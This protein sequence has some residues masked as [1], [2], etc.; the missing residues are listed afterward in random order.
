[1][2][3]R[4]RVGIIVLWVVSLAAVGLWG[5]TRVPLSGSR[6]ISGPDLGFRVDRVEGSRVTGTLMIKLDGQWMVVG[7]A[8]GVRPLTMR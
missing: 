5:Q 1:M 6:I 8:S 4:T 7:D 2:S 3:M